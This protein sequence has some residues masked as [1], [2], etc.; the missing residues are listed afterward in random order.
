[1]SA[2]R[3]QAPAERPI[4]AMLTP[5]DYFKEKGYKISTIGDDISWLRIGQDGRLYAVNPEN[6]F[7]GVAPGTNEKSNPNALRTTHKGTIFTNVARNL[8]DN[9]VW[10][11]KLDKNPPENGED[12]QGNPWNGR[13]PRK[14]AL[15]RI[16][17]LQRRQRTADHRR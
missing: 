1:M 13:P 2:A 9:T 15:I 3:S 12:W 11:E 4:L 16:Q 14:R 5:P 17:D 7:F 6:G 8:D 10:W